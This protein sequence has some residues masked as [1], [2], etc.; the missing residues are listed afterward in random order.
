M[1]WVSPPIAS[2]D[3]V[4]T[5]KSILDDLL[6]RRTVPGRSSDLSDDVAFIRAA[7]VEPRT[8][9]PIPAH[10]LTAIAAAP[11]GAFYVTDSPPSW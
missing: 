8:P 4:A 9:T 3:G 7:P 1:H 2:S 6:G 5:T 10:R 11:A